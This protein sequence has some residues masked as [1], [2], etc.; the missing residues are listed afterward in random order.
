V[1][2]SARCDKVDQANVN[3]RVLFPGLDGLSRWLARYC[4]PAAACR[5]IRQRAPAAKIPASAKER[6][7][8]GPHLVGESLHPG[9]VRVDP[10]GEVEIRIPHHAV[11][12]AERDLVVVNEQTII[13]A[14]MSN[15]GQR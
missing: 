14:W 2:S 4:R 6:F 1:V 9:G 15:C 13:E 8:E 5:T 10:V 3:E 7:E 12:A 11:V